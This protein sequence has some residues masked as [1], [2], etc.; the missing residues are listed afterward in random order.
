[1]NSLY[2]D[3]YIGKAYG[4]NSMSVQ[5][6]SSSSLND[7][8]VRIN[9]L[10]NK[11]SD[12][13]IS[14]GCDSF[15]V[16]ENK[17]SKFPL[18]TSTGEYADNPVARK[19]KEEIDAYFPQYA[20]MTDDEKWKAIV[21]KYTKDGLTTVKLHSMLCDLKNNQLI[22]PNVATEIALNAAAKVGIECIDYDMQ[23]GI[24]GDD[25]TSIIYNALL[26]VDD[27]FSSLSDFSKNFFKY[28]ENSA[29]YK[30]LN[31]LFEKISSLSDS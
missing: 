28:D 3:I 22:D 16:S 17:G 15:E 8:L 30:Q 6:V 19:T 25:D 5:A 11:P 29:Y 4:G 12:K 31:E 20:G 9:K 27:F 24:V 7:I 2:D 13:A 1:V 26:S 14:T 23:N 21:T 18:Y 10:A